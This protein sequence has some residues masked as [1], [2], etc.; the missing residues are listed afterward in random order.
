MARL[1]KRFFVEKTTR[2]AANPNMPHT[3]VEKLFNTEN[4]PKT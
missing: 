4:Y 3:P 1:E 2:K